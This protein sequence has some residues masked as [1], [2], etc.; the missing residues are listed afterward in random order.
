M[1]NRIVFF[2]CLFSLTISLGYAQSF[3][4]KFAVGLN[5]VKNEYNGDYGNGIFEFNKSPYLA[6]GISLT[7]YI[8]PSI[9]AGL[10]GSYGTYGYYDIK[11]NFFRGLKYDGSVFVH[12]KFNNGRILKE[13]SKLSPF[14][15]IGIGLAAYGINTALDSSLVNTK[16]SPTIITKGTDIIIPIGI[17]LKYQLSNLFAIQY[18]YLYTFTNAD[19][20]DDN[21]G[22]LNTKPGNDAYGQHLI[23]II[24]SFNNSFNNKD[25]RCDFKWEYLFKSI[26]YYLIIFTCG[27]LTLNGIK[28]IKLTIYKLLALFFL[29]IYQSDFHSEFINVAYSDTPCIT[30]KQNDLN[31]LIYPG[32]K[33]VNLYRVKLYIIM[34]NHYTIS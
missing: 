7:R 34:L 29:I 10:Q 20:H 11:E 12:Y 33:I 9:D 30:D 19:N 25:C 24:Y 8:S 14:I 13:D 6:L 16:Y 21:R 1:L 26:N 15:S 27:T 3:E 32:W 5:F 18:Q 23:G 4:N 2:I 22:H 17:G 31:I 28:R